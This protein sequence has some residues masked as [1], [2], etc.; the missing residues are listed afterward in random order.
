MM[1]LDFIKQSLT[2]TV[3]WSVIGGAGVGT[4][5][6]LAFGEKI[7]RASPLGNTRLTEEERIFEG[8][9][10][11]FVECTWRLQ[12]PDEVLCTSLSSN[13]EGQSR[14]QELMQLVGKHV[15]DVEIRLPAGDLEITFEDKRILVVFADQANEIDRWD[16]YTFYSPAYVMKN[17]YRSLVSV[18][19]RA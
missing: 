10:S 16:N 11:L 15:V 12:T 8:E 13:L 5:I 6:S 4:A 1:K 18:L 3:C 7:P 9:F 17:G 2:S 14:H 19:P